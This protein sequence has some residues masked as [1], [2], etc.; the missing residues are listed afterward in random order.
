MRSSSPLVPANSIGL[1]DVDINRLP[2]SR[3]ELVTQ[4]FCTVDEW[5]DVRVDLDHGR[6]AHCWIL[7]G[8]GKITIQVMD[9]TPELRLG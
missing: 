8:Q 4:V 6:P 1:I 5:P 9:G 3:L 7:D 2:P